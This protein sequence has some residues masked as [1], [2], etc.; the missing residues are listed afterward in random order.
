MRSI[1]SLLFIA[2]VV[3]AQEQSSKEPRDERVQVLLKNGHSMIGIAKAGVRTERLVRGNFKPG[4]DAT[5]RG[6]GIR[7]WYY[8]DLDGYIF[9]ESRSLERVD[10]LGTLTPEE[11]RALSD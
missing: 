1:L 7:V 6:S 4:T 5:D 2:A 11:S 10:V 8:Q 3:V 9:L